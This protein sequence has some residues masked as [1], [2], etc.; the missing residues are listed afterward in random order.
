[1]RAG[2]HR[3]HCSTHPAATGAVFRVRVTPYR[4]GIARARPLLREVRTSQV[5]IGRTDCHTARRLR[6]D[7][8]RYGAAGVKSFHP[9]CTTKVAARRPSSSL[10]FSSTW[11]GSSSSG[12]TEASSKEIAS[13]TLGS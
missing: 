5:C 12:S 13:P 8:H 4:P 2:A 9:A 7:R 6:G 10:T 1:M 3:R 11:A